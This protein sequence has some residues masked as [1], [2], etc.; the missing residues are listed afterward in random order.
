M[1]PAAANGPRLPPAAGVLL[2]ATWATALG[3]HALR[4]PGWVVVAV[5]LL[6]AWRIRLELRGGRELP[7]WLVFGLTILGALGVALSAPRPLG[8]DAALLLLFLLGGLKLLELRQA[9]D[10]VLLVFLSWFLVLANLLYDPSPAAAVHMGATV[11]VSAGA[12]VCLSDARGNLGWRGGLGVAGRLLAPALPLALVVFLLF[13]RVPGRLWSLP[14]DVSRGL[15]G[16]SETM[17]PGSVTDIAL[18][19]AVAFRADFRGTLP[20]SSQRYW[21]GLVLQDTDG[22]RWTAGRSPQ[23]VLAGPPETTADALEHEV[24]LEPHG[25]RWLFALDRPVSAPEGARLTRGSELRAAAPVVHRRRYA[26]RSLPGG[27]GGETQGES[28]ELAAALAL[29]AV[30]ARVRGLAQEWAQAAGAPSG[31]LDG[32]A[33]VRQALDFFRR[34]PFV[35]TLSP[36]LLGR[37][38]VDAFL[39]EARAG[40]CEHFAAAFTVLMRAAGV[41]A[42]VVAGYLGG[43]ENPL[44][45]YLLVLQ[46][47]A[48]AWSEVWLEERGW[49]RV[50]PTTAV[51]PERIERPILRM[52]GAGSLPVR[53]ALPGEGPLAAGIRWTRAAWDALG[54]GWNRWVLGYDYFRQRDLMARLGYRGATWRGLSIALAAAGGVFLAGLALALARRGAGALELPEVRAYRRFCRRLDRTGVPRRPHEGP[55]DLASRIAQERA[56]LADAARAVLEPYQRLRYAPQLPSGAR[57][58][59]LRRLRRAVRAFRPGRMPRSAGPK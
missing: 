12:L 35:Y 17:S 50:D 2:F 45:G 40:F 52:L 10:R 37:D 26:V 6:G 48:H 58:E 32:E 51:A 13:P 57:Q 18:S 20:P 39:F 11:L 24:T 36:P 30:S 54:H 9:R 8:R 21:R 46:A 22:V 41:P 56:D 47:D 42:R 5:A 15:S 55:L 38:P 29:P 33:V 19:D 3:P 4:V 59:E 25:K 1:T 49:V 28:P 27:S 31:R 16:F 43:E 53:F 14:A 34:E 7:R 23:E 44:G